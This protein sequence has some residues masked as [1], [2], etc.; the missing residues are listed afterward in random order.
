MK[1]VWAII[2]F[3]LVSVHVL[4][5]QPEILINRNIR[6]EQLPQNFGLSQSSV[7]CILQDHSGYIWI[8]TWSG[9]IRYDGY[10]TELFRANNRIPGS[11]KSNKITSIFEAS[12]SSLWIGTMVGGL[13]LFDRKTEIFTQYQK[14]DSVASSLSDNNVW[15]IEED[16]HHNIWIATQ[17]GLNKL[18]RKTGQFQRWYTTK[19]DSNSLSFNFLTS[20]HF[21]KNDVLWATSEQGVNRIQLNNSSAID[22]KR[23]YYKK[24]SEWGKLHNYV[25]NI[26]SLHI[27]G[28]DYVFWT[29]KKGLK[30]FDG[31][32]I[33][34][35]E[36]PNVSASFSFF[37]SLKVVDGD[38]AF[39]ILG[40]ERG[41]SF[42]D[43]KT[44]KFTKLLD[45]RN[46]EVNLSQNT[47]TSI[48]LDT[49][50]VLWV[51]TKKGINKFD[52]YSN[53]FDMYPIEAF[54]PT[55][56]I[57]TGIVQSGTTQHWLSTLGG[58][59]FKITRS[60][61]NQV[62]IEGYQIIDEE[63]RDISKYVQKIAADDEGNIWVGTAGAGVYMFNPEM[64]VKNSIKQ[65]KKFKTNGRGA[66]S[67]DYVMSMEN[68]I[69][70]GMWIGTWSEGLNKVGHSEVIRYTESWLKESPIV[71]IFQ[72]NENTLW[73]GTR[74]NGLIRINL[75]GADIVSFRRYRSKLGNNVLSNDF[76]NVIFKDSKDRLWVGTEDGLNLFDSET[77]S[78]SAEWSERLKNKEVIGMLEDGKGRLWLANFSG[79]E[80]INP[81]SNSNQPLF[82]FDSQDRLQGGFFYN[83]VQ[84]SSDN[85]MLLFGGTDGFNIIDPRHIFENPHLP[86]VIIRS[87]KIFNRTVKAGGSMEERMILSQPV[88]ETNSII[89][90]HNENSFSFEFTA[91][92]FAIPEKNKFA[93]QLVG[94]DKEWQYTTSN[95]R[96]A[97][98]TNLEGGNYVFRVKASNDDGIWN[99]HPKE[100]LIEIKPPW[101]RTT[102]AFASYILFSILLL[103]LFR[104]LI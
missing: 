14:I 104:K 81:N 22:I 50:G 45:N 39:V 19:S 4:L 36:I 42:F 97:N 89:L 13:F 1:K 27:N 67:D 94:F 86:Q 26:E 76:I 58:G 11:L 74:G 90:E 32:K 83:E 38:H 12:D 2:Y 61:N 70:G 96:F 5:G 25:Y 46:D 15:G 100:I 60:L 57:I 20:L 44:R 47:V 64:N 91:A 93:Y 33:E 92:H 102:Y 71:S 43:I 37:R 52:T 103:F 18:D 56:S 62:K 69:N 8:G 63:D 7:N 95:R 6:F 80:V 10:S 54:D 16:S 28:Q 51:G 31:Q 9:L 72:E 68:A 77:N 59:L 88:N 78:F 101:W 85:G 87:F 17:N 29:T 75:S 49:G 21:D 24:D 35:F 82:S 30:I 41:I 73:L 66:I 34:S 40:S 3:V 23:Y 79:L 48:F 55:K 98:Y 65:Y 53:N 84:S 99:E